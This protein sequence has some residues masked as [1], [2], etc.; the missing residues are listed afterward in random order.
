MRL[1][2]HY[3]DILTNLYKQ[4]LRAIRDEEANRQER[5]SNKPS[6]SGAGL[7][8]SAKANNASG[9]INKTNLAIGTTRRIRDKEHLRY[10]AAQPCLICGRS[11]GQ[12]HHLRF[13]QPRALGCKVSDEWV[14]PLCA[15][16][17]RALHST[18]DEERWWRERG[19]YPIRQAE[20]LWRE[21]RH[22]SHEWDSGNPGQIPAGRALVIRRE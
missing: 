2:E 18:G 8:G 11:P 21:T 20:K 5:G 1:G 7:T 15:T 10:V 13:A 17:H 6:E 14:V 16:H 12:A 19:V 4:Q 22:P 3:A 9:P